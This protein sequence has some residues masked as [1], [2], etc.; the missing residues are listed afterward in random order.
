MR[1]L[2]H[3]VRNYFLLSVIMLLMS[4]PAFYVVIQHLFIEKL[5]E[6]LHEHRNDFYKSMPV[7]KTDADI[8]LYALLNEEFILKK[9]NRKISTDSLYTAEMYDSAGARMVPYRILR[10]GVFLNNQ[11]YE[12]LIHESLIGTRELILVIVMI[13]G[14]I[15]SAL[16]LG[17]I[18]VNRSIT[19]K[20][21]NPFYQ[22]LHQLKQYELDKNPTL[23]V[24]ASGITEFQDLNT[25]IAQLIERN[26]QVYLN[27]KEFTENA[28]HELQTPLAISRTKLELLMQT[29]ELTREQADLIGSLYEATER[30]TR[31]NK[32]L[33]LLTKIENRQFIEKETVNLNSLVR[34]LLEF[35]QS[36]LKDRKIEVQVEQESEVSISANHALIEILLSNL[37][38]NAVRYTS[39]SGN[40]EISL[41]PQAFTISNAGPPF[42]NA[43]KIFE[44]FHRESKTH[45]GS[46]LGLAIVRK[47]GEVSGYAIAYHYKDSM[48]HFTVRF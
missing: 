1:L 11:H 6:E 31:L 30:L 43:T 35:H 28:S 46:G 7:L 4:I 32:N 23:P 20:V 38:S 29:K 36:Q 39:T 21:W 45:H 41:T 34:Q 14:V 17:L 33:L 3:T 42:E 47:I 8:E 19:K 44:R 9:T 13:K 18:I 12:L 10:S 26:H 27:Q 24:I 5:D 2:T 25:A 37:L 48:H 16:L 22:T 15:L 40:I